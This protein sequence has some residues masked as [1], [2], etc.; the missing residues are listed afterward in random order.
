[1]AVELADSERLA[2]FH[3]EMHGR[4][5]GYVVVDRRRDYVLLTQR[6]PAAHRWLSD[7]TDDP[8]SLASLYECA[9][10]KLRSGYVHRRWRVIRTGLEECADE[11]ERQR[12]GC[13]HAVVLAQPRHLTLRTA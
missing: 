1:M 10:A 12:R 9:T 2:A 13:A 4:L 6:L 11:F 3:R 7:A 5:Y 8:P